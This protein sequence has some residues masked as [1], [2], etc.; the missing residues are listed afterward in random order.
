LRDS[1]RTEG[2]DYRGRIKTELKPWQNLAIE[3]H[4]EQG[5][6]QFR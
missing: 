3:F 6:F 4:A 2:F 5:G 1:K